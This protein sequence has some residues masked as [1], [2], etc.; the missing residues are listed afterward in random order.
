MKTH[1]EN[2][3]LNALKDILKVLAVGIPYIVVMA[4]SFPMTAQANIFSDTIDAIRGHIDDVEGRI[5]HVDKMVD[6][7]RIVW[8]EFRRDDI[9]R[10]A[11]HWANGT[12][13]L[14]RNDNGI[15]LQ[16]DEDFNTGPAPDLYIYAANSKVVDEVSFWNASGRFELAKLESGSGAQFYNVTSAPQFTE[17]IIWCKRF[18][19]FIGAVTLEIEDPWDGFDWS[20]FGPPDVRNR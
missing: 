5:N 3:K 14:I 11:I 17:V 15:Y 9:G 18:G 7:N 6:G 10:D 20:Q 12:A 4:L 13:S 16:F 1:L 19:A 2:Y 8:D